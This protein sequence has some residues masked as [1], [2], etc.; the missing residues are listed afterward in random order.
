MKPREDIA[1]LTGLRGLA[2]LLVVV[3]HYSRWMAVTPV[4][5]HPAWTERLGGSANIGMAIFFTLSG[6]VIAL[7]YGDWDWRSRPGFNLA[8]FLFYRFA[9]LYPAFFLFAALVI[10]RQPKLHDLTDGDVESYVLPHLMLA[11][12]VADEV[13]RHR[14]R[15]QLLPCIVEHQHGM[16][17]LSA[18]RARCPADGVA[19][20]MAIPVAHPRRGVLHGG[21]VPAST[22]VVETK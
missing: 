2:A 22:G 5:E 7:S 4:A 14:C 16:G 21:S 19:A 9:R 18:V 10:M 15:Q 3:T 12:L 13:R 20:A 6:Y 1:S 8:R 17:A 11:D